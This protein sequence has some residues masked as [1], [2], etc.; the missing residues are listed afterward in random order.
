VIH[1]VAGGT[2][3][4]A[5]FIIA[6]TTASPVHLHPAGAVAPAYPPAG[7]VAPAYPPAGAVAPAYPPAGAVAPAYHRSRHPPIAATR[8]H[9]GTPENAN[10]Y[11]Q[12]SQRPESET[13]TFQ[14]PSFPDTTTGI[15]GGGRAGNHAF[16]FGQK[17]H[18][19]VSTGVRHVQPHSTDTAAPIQPRHHAFI[20]PPS[21]ISQTNPTEDAP[22]SHT[23]RPAALIVTAPHPARCGFATSVSISQNPPPLGRITHVPRIAP[24]GD[25]TRTTK[26]PSA[27]RARNASETHPVRTNAPHSSSS[28]SVI[29]ATCTAVHFTLAAGGSGG[30]RTP[31]GD[32]AA[33]IHGCDHTVIPAPALV[34]VKNALP[35]I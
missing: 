23:A 35:Q 32:I 6:R 26:E 14:P 24:S 29:S 31:S 11:P 12:P 19:F 7:A 17:P 30:S 18:S 5:R 27:R 21:G 28:V 34:L 20:S 16:V 2:G 15:T 13:T 9:S 3:R 1:A 22:R 33:T 8:S 4:P 10:T 25:H